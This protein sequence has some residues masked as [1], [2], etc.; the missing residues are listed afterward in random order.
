MWTTPQP[1]WASPSS[2]SFGQCYSHN[3]P[4]SQWRPGLSTTGQSHSSSSHKGSS[5]KAP[6]TSF[7]RSSHQREGKRERERKSSEKRKRKRLKKERKKERKKTRYLQKLIKAAKKQSYDKLERLLRKQ[8][9]RKVVN[10]RD[11]NGQT[12]LHIAVSNDDMPCVEKL[13]SFDADPSAKDAAGNTC[14][15]LAA[16]AG[17]VCLLEMLILASRAGC[18]D[19]NN[20]GLSPLQIIRSQQQ[21]STQDRWEQ[22]LE[23]EMYAENFS[24]QENLY[25]EWQTDHDDD[26]TEEEYIKYIA[27]EMWKRQNADKIRADKERRQKEKQKQEREAEHR[28]KMDEFEERLRQRRKESA[29]RTLQVQCEEYN[30]KWSGLQGRTSQATLRF[31]DIPWPPANCL[32]SKERLATVQLFLQTLLGYV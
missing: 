22:K 10:Q 8:T 18:M 29:D 14:F 1:Q 11:E 4:Q 25:N 5:E 24:W 26:L 15:H 21:Q 17:N 27:E 32:Q 6:D 23:D 28:R 31:A 20:A 3:A 12:C 19:K 9:Y 2:Y 30:A 13:L 7:S 16:Y